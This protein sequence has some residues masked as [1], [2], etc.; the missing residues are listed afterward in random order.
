VSLLSF[1]A[2]KV[3]SS[4]RG[5]ALITD[6]TELFEK[7]LSLRN[8][9]PE[10]KISKTLQHL[11]HFPIFW[12]GKK[13]YGLYLGKIILAV[14]Q[15][16]QL[17]NKVIYDKEKAGQPVDFYPSKFANSLAE[18]LLGQLEQ[19]EKMNMHRQ[20]IANFYEENI[21]SS[22]IK[23]P[24]RDEGTNRHSPIGEGGENCIYLRYPVLTAEPKKLFALAKKQ[25]VILGNWYDSVIA[26]EDIDMTK[27][28]YV[29]GSCP[30]AE[31]LAPMSV[32]L[33]TDR[34]IKLKDAEKVV[35]IINRFQ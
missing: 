28:R 22:K 33:P 18:I 24:W 31:R 3:V 30:N 11:A 16:L 7:I 26:P 29:Q 25:K 5:G 32:N 15:K 19:V 20:E 34:N 27:T 8:A 23:L 2:D 1:G 9:L 13:T 4:A 10:P 35:E 12:L 17:M 14:S 21:I 6:N